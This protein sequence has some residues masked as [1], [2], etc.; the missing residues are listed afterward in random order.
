MDTKK[1]MEMSSFWH[2]KTDEECIQMASTEYGVD[3][4]EALSNMFERDF[5]TQ[6]NNNII[7]E[8]TKQ[9]LDEKSVSE[10]VNDDNINITNEP[11]APQ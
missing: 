5:W 7:N 10:G 4:A 1:L 8:L 3:A 6:T 9:V 2:N 11:D